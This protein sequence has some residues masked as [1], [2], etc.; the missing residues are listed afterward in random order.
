MNAVSRAYVRGGA[1]ALSSGLKA[2]AVAVNSM[3]KIL[4]G[5]FFCKV[6]AKNTTIT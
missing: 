6:P 1:Q 5:G 3:G 4:R 2:S